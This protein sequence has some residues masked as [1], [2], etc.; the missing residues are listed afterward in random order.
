MVRP[1]KQQRRLKVKTITPLTPPASPY[2]PDRQHDFTERPTV[3]NDPDLT[4]E[5]KGVTDQASIDDW[6]VPFVI[7]YRP[8][9]IR[10]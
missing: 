6:E 4:P 8:D 3:A 7:D 2:L 9:P 1:K 5:V 10:R